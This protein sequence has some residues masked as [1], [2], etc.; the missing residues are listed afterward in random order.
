MGLLVMLIALS[1]YSPAPDAVLL[2]QRDYVTDN[3]VGKGPEPSPLPREPRDPNMGQH[4]G[5]KDC[6]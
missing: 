6:W 3:D 4:P 2:D 5:C 1:S